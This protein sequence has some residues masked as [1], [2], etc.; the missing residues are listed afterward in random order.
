MELSILFVMAVI[1]LRGFLLE[2]FLISTGSMAPGLLGLH[3]RIT[4]PSCDY[5]FAFGSAYDASVNDDDSTDVSRNYATC[6]NCGQT[7]INAMKIPANHGDQLL[8]HKGVFDFRRP[9]RWEPIV[10]RNPAS[11]GEAYLKRVVG[12]PGE[13]LQVIDGDLF[14]EGK[15]ARK[16]YPCERSCLQ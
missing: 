5:S 12:L 3:K 7:N 4:C 16:D 2:G 15:I 10:F 13:T 9:N 11:P 8:V 6:P 1:M 14:I